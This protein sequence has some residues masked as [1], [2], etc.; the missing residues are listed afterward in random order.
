MREGW[1]STP[2]SYPSPNQTGPVWPFDPLGRGRTY[3]ALGII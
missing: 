2:F 1:N 3:M